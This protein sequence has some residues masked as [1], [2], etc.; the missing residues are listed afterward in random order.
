MLWAWVRPTAGHSPQPH[1]ARPP[2]VGPDGRPALEKGV[3]F[4]PYGSCRNGNPLQYSWPKNSKD[5]GVWQIIVHGIAE[6]DTTENTC[7]RLEAAR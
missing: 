3:F 6:S 1:P 4:L 5:R 7:M 2:A